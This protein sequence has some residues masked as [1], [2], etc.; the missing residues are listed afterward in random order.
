M[1]TRTTKPKAKYDRRFPMPTQQTRTEWDEYM[2]RADEVS[3][4]LLSQ[5]IEHDLDLAINKYYDTPYNPETD[6]G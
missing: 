4:R 6:N 2:R 5:T 1:T 3:F